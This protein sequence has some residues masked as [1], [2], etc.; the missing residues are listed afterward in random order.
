MV[1]AMTTS[2]IRMFCWAF[3]AVLGIACLVAVLTSKRLKYEK[4]LDNLRVIDAAMVSCAMAN[5]YH[6]GDKTSHK[7][8]LEFLKD[9]ALP[10]CPSGGIYT[11]PLVGDFPECSVHRGILEKGGPF[12]NHKM[13]LSRYRPK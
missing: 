8:V 12:V 7:L 1:S 3:V 11:I 2:R 10:K 4:C 9:G 6:T 5:N 13:P